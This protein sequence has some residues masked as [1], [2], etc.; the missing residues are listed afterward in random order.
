MVMM[1]VLAKEIVVGGESKSE[2]RKESWLAE[3]RK[4]DW[5]NIFL[6]QVYTHGLNVASSYQQKS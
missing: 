3:G 4:L 2:R 6:Y 1:M 5:I